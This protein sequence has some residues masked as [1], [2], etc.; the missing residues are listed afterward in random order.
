M[1]FI[2]ETVIERSE[3]L[4]AVGTR[5]FEAFEKKHLGTGIELLEEMAELSH[6]IAA[7][8]NAENV[9]HQ[10]FHELLGKILTAQ[11]SLRQFT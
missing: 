2:H 3:I 9:M 6:R 10:S 4:E 8:G 7:G 1:E 5:F 11:V